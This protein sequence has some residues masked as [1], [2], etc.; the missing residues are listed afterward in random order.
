[1]NNTLKL[2]GKIGVGIAGYVLGR[3]MIIKSAEYAGQA[4]IDY[5][6]N[7]AKEKVEEPKEEQEELQEQ[8]NKTKA[9]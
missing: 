9:I 6:D 5:M 2:V 8:D 1:M 4:I 7:K 3:R